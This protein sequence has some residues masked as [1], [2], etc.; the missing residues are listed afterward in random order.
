MHAHRHS[1]PIKV[2][3]QVLAIHR[4]LCGCAAHAAA[5]P[6]AAGAEALLH[7]ALRANQHKRV[8]AH[9]TRN[10]HRLTNRAVLLRNRGMSGGK[11]SGRALAMDTDTLHLPIDLIL[12]HLGDVVAHIV[13]HRQIFGRALR[14]K[15]DWKA[16]R[17][18]CINNWRLAQAKLAAQAIAPRY[19]CPSADCKGRQASCRS[20]RSKPNSSCF[21]SASWM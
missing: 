17:T 9:I 19:A 14:P 5:C 21:A 10:E 18:P 12:L 8:T 16:C 3:Q 1:L 6:M 20:T 4:L 15:T 13:D 11:G 7:R 2:F